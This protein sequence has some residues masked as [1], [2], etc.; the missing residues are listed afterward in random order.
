M[1]EL[2]VLTQGEGQEGRDVE[3]RRDREVDAEMQVDELEALGIDSAVGREVAATEAQPLV[4]CA[5]SGPRIDPGLGHEVID[6]LCAEEEI[7]APTG[8]AARSVRVAVVSRALDQ[9]ISVLEHRPDGDV[10]IDAPAHLGDDGDEPSVAV[11]VPAAGLQPRAR[12]ETGNPVRKA[13]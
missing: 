7:A 4:A 13:N 2:R 10:G 11:A 1:A 5:D 9:A 12:Q 6:A 8:V 3:A